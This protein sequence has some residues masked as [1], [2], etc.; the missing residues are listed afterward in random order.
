M[1]QSYLKQTGGGPDKVE[2]GRFN[3]KD[4]YH[5]EMDLYWQ[6]KYIRGAL[7]LDDAGLRTKML[8]LFGEALEKQY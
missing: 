5:G 6:G 2:E 8:K 4:P 7:N 1:L 3:L